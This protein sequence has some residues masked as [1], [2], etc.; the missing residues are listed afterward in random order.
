MVVFAAA[1]DGWWTCSPVAGAHTSAGLPWVALAGVL[2]TAGV[3]SGCWA[4]L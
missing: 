4:N 1:R 2:V 3:S